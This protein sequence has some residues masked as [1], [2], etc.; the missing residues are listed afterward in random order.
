MLKRWVESKRVEP[1]DVAVNCGN[2]AA[3]AYTDFME[4]LIGFQFAT[5]AI[6]ISTFFSVPWI[7]IVVKLAL[8]R[9]AEY[10]PTNKTP[11]STNEDLMA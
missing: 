8:A 5:K 4:I 11:L 7:T 3:V 2:E 9:D 10:L 1:I 6:Q